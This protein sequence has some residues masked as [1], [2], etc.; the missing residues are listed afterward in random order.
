MNRVTTK[1]PHNPSRLKS[2]R[3]GRL[4]IHE[5]SKQDVQILLN[6]YEEAL[7]EATGIRPVPP[8]DPRVEQQRLNTLHHPELKYPYFHTRVD[9]VEEPCYPRQTENGSLLNP[10]DPWKELHKMQDAYRQVIEQNMKLQM[11]VMELE[12]ELHS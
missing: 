6:E 4:R 5:M 12:K 11:Q 8:A 9:G 1:K 3:E 10:I 2:Y 7:F